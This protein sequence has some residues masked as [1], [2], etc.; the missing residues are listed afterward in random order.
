MKQVTVYGPGCK[1]CAATEQMIRDAAG[2]LGVEV[3]VEKMPP[4]IPVEVLPE[5][6]EFATVP[7]VPIVMPPPSVLAVLLRM[8]LRSIVEVP[9]PVNHKPPPCVS[10]VLSAIVTPVSTTTADAALVSPPPK[11]VVA[12]LP[13]IVPPF[14]S[15]RDVPAA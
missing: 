1:R 2:R 12:V 13:E 11:E 6:V 4:P 10:A 9:F 14:S 8:V 15:K 5:T 7:A 3:A